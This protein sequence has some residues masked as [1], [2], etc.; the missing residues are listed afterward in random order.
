M[1]DGNFLRCQVS[2]GPTLNGLVEAMLPPPRLA[3]VLRDGQWVQIDDPRGQLAVF[4]GRGGAFLN[5]PA[6][7]RDRL[8][9]NVSRPLTSLHHGAPDPVQLR[10]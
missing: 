5:L 10:R 1:P 3:G 7:E 4:R 9:A 2:T 6:A 8:K